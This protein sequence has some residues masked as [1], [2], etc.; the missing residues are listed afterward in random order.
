MNAVPRNLRIE[1]LI[2]LSSGR[3]M[4]RFA[5]LEMRKRIAEEFLL[6][7]DALRCVEIETK[8]REPGALSVEC[9][10]WT[11][12]AQESAVVIRPVISW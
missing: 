11:R 9:E 8:I 5:P 12:D 7:M 6:R 4:E 3:N 1:T 2:L 10:R